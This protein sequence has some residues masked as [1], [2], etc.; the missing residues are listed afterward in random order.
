MASALAS[1]AAYE[2]ICA[3]DLRGR[4]AA[5]WAMPPRVPLARLAAGDLDRLGFPAGVL[6]ACTVPFDFDDACPP[7]EQAEHAEQA[8]QAPAPAPAP[9]SAPATATAP[10]PA[11]AEH[12]ERVPL[13]SARSAIRVSASRSSKP[14]KSNTKTRTVA[15]KVKSKSGTKKRGGA[16]SDIELPGGLAGALE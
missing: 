3:A 10:A 7:T 15:R 16:S 14:V 1:L 11:P 5:G 9:A 6:E 4:A 2:R 8:E 13:A 12:T